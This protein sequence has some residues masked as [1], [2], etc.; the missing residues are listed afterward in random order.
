MKKRTFWIFLLAA[1]LVVL[2]GGNA[3]FSMTR[4]SQS[5]QAPTPETKKETPAVRKVAAEVPVHMRAMLLGGLSNSVSQLVSAGDNVDVL[6]TFEAVTKRGEKQHITVTLLQN[7]KVLAVGIQPL[8]SSGEK[9]KYN[10]YVVLS[11]SPRDAQYL[12]LA[13]MEGNVD[14]TVRPTGEASNFIMEI[15]SFDKLFQVGQD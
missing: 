9:S 5:V 4:R 3:A 6:A 1:G 8:I 15:S 2:S 13:R 12:A 14:V 11:L 10:G 7:V